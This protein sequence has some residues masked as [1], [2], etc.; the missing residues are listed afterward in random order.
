MFSPTLSPVVENPPA[1]VNQAGSQN[2]ESVIDTFNVIQPST[3]PLWKIVCVCVLLGLNVLDF[4]M[5]LDAFS[6]VNP[7]FLCSVGR[8]QVC[9]PQLWSVVLTMF[10]RLPP[11]RKSNRGIR[12]TVSLPAESSWFDFLPNLEQSEL[13][14]SIVCWTDWTYA[15]SLKIDILFDVIYLSCS[16][17]GYWKTRHLFLWVC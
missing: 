14:F 17:A 11:Q 12:R 15:G 7:H 16:P 2:R 10:L 6:S 1:A 3:W 4:L 8:K 13:G 5:V 9:F